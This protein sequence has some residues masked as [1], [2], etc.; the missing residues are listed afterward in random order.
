MY[1]QV[2][3]LAVAASLFMLFGGVGTAGA[4]TL[5]DTQNNVSLWLGN[6]LPIEDEIPTYIIKEAA[7]SQSFY[8]SLDKNTDIEDVFFSLDTNSSSKMG[9]GF[10]TINPTS[11]DDAIGSLTVSLTQGRLFGDMLFDVLL[12]SFDLSKKDKNLLYPFRVQALGQGGSELFDY[13]FG[14][15][16]KTLKTGILRSCGQT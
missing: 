13:D 11:M 7:G 6:Q 2:K 14:V 5:I 4:A 16:S 9:N 15:D 8:G 3:K 12:K 10:A 1:A